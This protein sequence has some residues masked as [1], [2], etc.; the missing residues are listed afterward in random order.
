MRSYR[1]HPSY[2]RALTR[3]RF[4]SAFQTFSGFSSGIGIRYEPS[5]IVNNVHQAHASGLVVGERM[6][7]HVFVQAADVRPVN[8]HDLLPSDAR[9]KIIVFA[10]VRDIAAPAERLARVHALAEAMDAHG[11]FLRRFGQGDHTKVFDFLCV[12][13]AD[14][15]TVDWTGESPP[16]SQQLAQE[17]DVPSFP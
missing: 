5:A 15:D 16:S 14:K 6:V 7:P 1:Q 9:F 3:L 2:P 12:L 4:P 8:I 11:G 17:I 13:G 10:W